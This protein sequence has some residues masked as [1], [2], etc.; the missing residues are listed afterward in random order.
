MNWL[1]HAKNAVRADA[2]IAIDATGHTL[3]IFGI[4]L[5]RHEHGAPAR[6]PSCSSYQVAVDFR[7]DI[8]PDAPYVS[9][10]ARCGWVSLAEPEAE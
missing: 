5:I 7:P 8:A 4:T 10:C 2:E 1:T 6:C 9:H 3:A